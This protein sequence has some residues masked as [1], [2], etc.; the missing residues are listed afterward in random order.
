MATVT[1]EI[2]DSSKEFLD[3]QIASGRFKDANALMQAAIDQLMRTQWKTGAE[4]KIDEALNE[5]ERGEF[6][7]WQRGDCEKL[8]RQ[9]LNDKR[10]QEQKS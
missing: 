7:S 3:Q 8:G 5:Y 4:R 1:V 2:T 9:Y 6:T 10:A